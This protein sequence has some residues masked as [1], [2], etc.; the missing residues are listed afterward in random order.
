MVSCVV[1]SRPSQLLSPAPSFLVTAVERK[2]SL[3]FPSALLLTLHAELL[4]TSF[5]AAAPGI[6]QGSPINTGELG[7][8][9]GG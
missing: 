4:E 8:S 1:Q 3:P 9:R 2:A 6:S 5:R 7:S